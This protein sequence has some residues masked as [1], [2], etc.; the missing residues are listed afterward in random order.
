KAAV[1]GLEELARQIPTLK[2]IAAGAGGEAWQACGAMAKRCVN[3]LVEP[4]SGGCHRGKVEALVAQL[5]A[6]RIL[7][8]TGFPNQNPGAALGLLS[9][10]QLSDGEK[11]NIFQ[12][13]AA[14]L[15]DLTLQG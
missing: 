6:H 8:A 1:E 12:R 4:F 14:R 2:F 11:Q 9:D 15:F 10:A 3:V 13:N 5:G 7:F